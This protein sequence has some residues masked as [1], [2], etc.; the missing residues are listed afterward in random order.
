ML[1]YA[2]LP[3]SCAWSAIARSRRR[4]DP[5]WSLCCQTQVETRI[6]MVVA[7]RLVIAVRAVPSRAGYSPVRIICSTTDRER[8]LVTACL[9][10]DISVRVGDIKNE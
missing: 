1:G 3:L 2:P 7:P 4:A 8:L 5:V 10:H 6:L 9:L